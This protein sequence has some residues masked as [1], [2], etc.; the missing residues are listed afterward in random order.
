MGII[1]RRM[2]RMELARADSKV[3]FR[4]LGI[5]TEALTAQMLEIRTLSLISSKEVRDLT[6]FKIHKNKP[7]GMFLDREDSRTSKG[8]G[9]L[10]ELL[11]ITRLTSTQGVHSM[12]WTEDQTLSNLRILLLVVTIR[13]QDHFRLA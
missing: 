5:S 7:L 9:S 3:L 8:R 12:P 1:T 2:D 13:L 4:D 10:T 11:R 6:G